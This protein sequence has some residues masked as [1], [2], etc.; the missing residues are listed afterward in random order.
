MNPDD[1]RTGPRRA[2]RPSPDPTSGTER[3]EPTPRARHARPEP[4][5]R[6]PFDPAPR[7]ALLRL[8]TVFLVGAVVGAGVVFLVRGD[9]EPD[10][11][12]ATGTASSTTSTPTS[13]PGTMGSAPG[14]T[15]APTTT[16]TAETTPS[17]PAPD[18]TTPPTPAATDPMAVAEALGDVQLPS[19]CGLPL[20]VPESLPNA[21]RGYRGGVHEGID[22]ICGELGRDAVAALDGQVVI[23]NSAFTDPT[24]EERLEILDTAKGLGRTPPWTLAMLFGRFV[25]IDHGVRDGV[26]HVVTIYAHLNAVDPAVRPGAHVVAGQRIGEIGNAGTESAG[27]GEVRPQAIH[28]HWEIHID[29]RFLGAGLSSSDTSAV[30]ARL[31]NA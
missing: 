3:R 6:R 21:D 22:F 31:F 23:A 29:D 2:P 5:R 20:G 26:G 24:P 17:V 12:V 30:Y 14:P 27:T 11:S 28:L 13:T 1:D 19:D 25:V 7:A 8:A 16:P 9:G 4:A 18:P 15:S 10:A